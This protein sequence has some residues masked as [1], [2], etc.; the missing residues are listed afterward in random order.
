MKGKDRKKWERKRDRKI[1][2]HQSAQVAM[3]ACSHGC[4]MFPRPLLS[5]ALTSA[6][7]GAPP[8]QMSTRNP[9][10]LELWNGYSF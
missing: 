6:S 2:Q 5:C 8:T 1:R 3:E 4:G 9:D 10:F 7:M